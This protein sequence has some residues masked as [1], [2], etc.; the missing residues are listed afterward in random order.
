MRRRAPSSTSVAE[1]PTENLGETTS[2]GFRI[3]VWLAVTVIAAA[4]VGPEVHQGDGFTGWS[5]ARAGVAIAVPRDATAAE[6][7][8]ARTVQS[9]FVSSAGLT[10]RHFPLISEGWLGSTVWAVSAIRAARFWRWIALKLD[11]GFR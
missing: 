10:P 6:L 5:S 8:A 3:A 4:L 1:H 2:T 7:N 11:W 9:T